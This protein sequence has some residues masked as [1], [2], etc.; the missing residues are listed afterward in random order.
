LSSQL[1]IFGFRFKDKSANPIKFMAIFSRRT[2]QRLINEN[3]DF[4]NKTQTRKHIDALNFNKKNIR[5]GLKAEK[6]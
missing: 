5:I 1:A 6:T 2:L 4:L 3:A